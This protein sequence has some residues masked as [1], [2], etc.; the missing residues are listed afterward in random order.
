MA[1]LTITID[2]ETLQRA[3]LR[4]LEQGT[5]V[6]A[7]LREHLEAFAGGRPAREAAVAALLDLSRRTEGRRGGRTWTRDELHER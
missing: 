1:N 7:L 4:A 3:R 6:N 2:E 5:S